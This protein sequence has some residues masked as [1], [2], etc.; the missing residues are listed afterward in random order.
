MAARNVADEGVDDVG[1]FVPAI[2]AENVEE[3]DW[4]RQLL[5]DHDISA[6]IDEDY[7]D[8]PPGSVPGPHSGTPVMVPEGSLDDAREVIAELEEMDEFDALVSETDDVDDDDHEDFDLE[9][10]PETDTADIIGAD[11][12]DH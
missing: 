1:R 5:E 7:S 4:Y 6:I 12:D 2:F 8:T 10:D 11:E 9:Y 3:A